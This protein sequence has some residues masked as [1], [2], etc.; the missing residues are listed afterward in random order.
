MKY[1]D[2]CQ[3][4]ALD[5]FADASRAAHREFQ[6]TLSRGPKASPVFHWLRELR[7]LDKEARQAET[8]YRDTEALDAELQ[9]HGGLA[10]DLSELAARADAAQQAFAL[11]AAAHPELRDEFLLRAEI[12]DIETQCVAQRREIARLQA[13][14]PKPPTEPRDT[15]AEA[16]RLDALAAV[17]RTEASKVTAEATELDRQWQAMHA[18][19]HAETNWL[20][21][22]K[23]H[24]RLKRIAPRVTMADRMAD[25]A[26]RT[27]TKAHT[28]SAK[29]YARYT[30]A[31]AEAAAHPVSLQ[32]AEAHLVTL[33]QSLIAMRSRLPTEAKAPLKER[34][35]KFREPVTP[36][37]HPVLRERYSWEP[38]TETLTRRS[39]GTPVTSASVAV[40]GIRVGRAALIEALCPSD[41]INDSRP[42]ASEPFNPYSLA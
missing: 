40:G 23:L 39:T 24:E 29:A 1:L 19:P 41:G 9:L 35:G 3:N 12:A 34:R 26:E 13:S 27:A 17:R 10:A 25:N 42:E 21:R 15:V 36:T 8:H 32:L 30:K 20:A 28:R 14:V 33:R 16:L 11:H 2:Y 5:P 18:D 31:Q 37:L 6:R 7:R 4:A 38:A 22:D